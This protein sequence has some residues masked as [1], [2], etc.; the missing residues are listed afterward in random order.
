MHCNAFQ[1]IISINW[2]NIFEVL[3]NLLSDLLSFQQKSSY[4]AQS[5]HLSSFK[6]RIKCQMKNDSGV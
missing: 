1:S 6:E 4:R 2:A 5:C 3:F